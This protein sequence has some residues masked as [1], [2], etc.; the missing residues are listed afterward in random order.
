MQSRRLLLLTVFLWAVSLMPAGYGRC[1]QEHEAGPPNLDEYD[2]A[3]RGRMSP[4]RGITPAAITRMDNNGELLI[5][6]YEPRTAVE[7]KSK[8]ICFTQSQLEVLTDWNLLAFDVKNKTYKTTVHIF[9][10]QETAEIR[11][12][13]GQGLDGLE[14]MLE[15]D[16]TEVRQYLVDSGHGESLFSV[17]Y[18]YV[19]H[20]YT[21]DQL[22]EEI[23]QKPALSAEHPFWNGFSWAVYPPWKFDIAP[24]HFAAEGTDFYALGG[25]AVRG[26]GLRDLLPLI[27]EVAIDRRIDNPELRKAFSAYGIVDKEGRLTVPIFEG[28]WSDRLENMARN[29]YERTAAIAATT[30]MKEILGMSTPSNAEMFI[31][32]EVRMAFLDH[33]LKE[34]AL[35]TP[36]NFENPEEN[37]PA[38]FSRLL[39]LIVPGDQ[40]KSLS[41]PE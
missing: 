40:K 32:Y 6:C 41:G 36:I 9:G 12:I 11:R 31:H 15:P 21:M 30:E 34:G 19:L 37:S 35:A 38:D 22:M 20:A 33:L 39:F 28:I 10:P 17:L 7:L 3:A 1:P 24:M 23:S 5:A 29:V 8:G 27:K 13:V 26:P 14:D 4:S 2:F 16:L 18:A 25:A